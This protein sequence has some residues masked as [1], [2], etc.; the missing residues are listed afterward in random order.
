MSLT[1]TLE[2]IGIVVIF[3]AGSALHFIYEWTGYWNPMA[4]KA[5][6]LAK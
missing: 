2:L 1:L 3:L 4:H 6:W 5:D